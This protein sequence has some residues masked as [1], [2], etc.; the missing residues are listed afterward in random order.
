VNRRVSGIIAAAVL[1]VIGTVTLTTYVQSARDGAE[2]SAGDVD[3]WVVDETIAK[4]TNG[5]DIEAHVTRT[6]VPRRLEAD[7]A[8]TD[9][10]D[11]DDLVVIETLLPGDQLVSSRFGTPAQV[12][13]AG[14]PAG[15]HAVTIELEP[16][17]ALGGQLRAGDKVDV[18]MSYDLTSE[19]ARATGA[20]KAT[21]VT[22][23][24]V[25][26]ASVQI[27][28]N[29]EGVPNVEAQAQGDDNEA[30]EDAPTE[31]LLVTL[32][33][34][35]ASVERLILGAEFGKIWLATASAGA[36]T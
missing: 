21:G 5:A 22:L 2:A 7:G 31:A 14:I 35:D 9:L 4:G 20:T 34:D 24:D 27:N 23:R 10:D 6:S 29:A 15:F 1:A 32:A 11:V 25:L 16:Q 8:L 3:V 28:P 19:A 30:V 36:A 17:R 26:V 33:V 12:R 18:V 13:Q